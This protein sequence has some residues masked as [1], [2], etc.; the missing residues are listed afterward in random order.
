[1]QLM[2]QSS[3]TTSI[4][5]TWESNQEDWEYDSDETD[6]D[7]ILANH[8]ITNSSD[9]EIVEIISIDSAESETN[10]FDEDEPVVEVIPIES[11][12][13]EIILLS[14][15]PSD[16]ESHVA[17]VPNN[18]QEL[19]SSEG[20]SSTLGIGPDLDL[21]GWGTSG[22]DPD[23]VSDSDNNNQDSEETEPTEAESNSSKSSS[24]RK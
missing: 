7:E 20:E 10:P 22:I 13:S 21:E 9:I 17:Q 12:P 5:N 18:D 23:P 2:L 1:M 16:M 11:S 8:E 4:D 14:S 3:Y 6:P 24:S 15:D 19:T